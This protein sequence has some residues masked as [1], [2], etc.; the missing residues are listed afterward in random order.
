MSPL[1]EL[2]AAVR[3]RRSEMGL[4]QTHL[5]ELSGLSRA[6]VNEVENGKLKDLSLNRAARLLDV[7][8]LSVSITP[9][10]ERHAAPSP[11]DRAL[12]IAARTASVSYKTALT[13]S[14]LRE[15]LLT[16][17]VPAKVVPHVRTLLDEAPIS[18]LALV[19]EQLHKEEGTDRS[20]VW[21]RMRE[22]AQGLKVFRKHWR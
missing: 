2:S 14:V 10:H 20:E 8:G 11:T 21:A 5:A 3:T 17:E 16:G 13:A 6:T 18:L 7:L 19:V 9:P 1:F 12:D 4:T 22:L 15:A